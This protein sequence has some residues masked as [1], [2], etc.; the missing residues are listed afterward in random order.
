[1]VQIRALQPN[2][3]PTRYVLRVTILIHI[4]KYIKA[5][6][7]PSS[8]LLAFRERRL[9]ARDLYLKGGVPRRGELCS[10]ETKPTKATPHLSAHANDHLTIT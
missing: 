8:Q 1:M 7:R 9:H 6:T 2:V 3:I 5:T 4:Q 10:V